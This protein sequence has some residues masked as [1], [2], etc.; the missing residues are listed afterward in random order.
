[1][2]VAITG[3]P[4]VGKTSLGECLA[5]SGPVL[6]VRD[7]A[8]EYG[9]AVPNVMGPLEIEVDISS[10]AALMAGHTAGLGSLVFI[11]GHLAHLLP[12]E[13]IIV[14]R[15]DPGELRSRLDGRGYPAEKLNENVEAEAVGVCLA[16]AVETGLPVAEVD[17]TR[18]SSQALAGMVLDI[19]RLYEAGEGFGTYSPG[20][21]DWLEDVTWV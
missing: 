12:A 11:E 5:V 4:G 3:T 6:S 7:L 14:L 2:D 17:A 9:C 18:K 19:L 20:S 15:L 21:V 1:M 13:I 16:E 10:L 8:L